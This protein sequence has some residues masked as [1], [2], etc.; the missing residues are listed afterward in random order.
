MSDYPIKDGEIRYKKSERQ[1]ADDM[2]LVLTLLEHQLRMQELAVASNNIERGRRASMLH[3]KGP[4][5]YPENP[6]YIEQ[7]KRAIQ[8]LNQSN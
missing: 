2:G 6:E 3:Y 4:A 7:L 8:I 1:P 5:L